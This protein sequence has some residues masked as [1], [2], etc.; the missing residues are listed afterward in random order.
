VT[1]LSNAVAAILIALCSP[2]LA[3]TLTFD[4]MPKGG[5]ALF[6][7]VFGASPDAATLGEMSAPARSEADWNAFLV[8]RGT[9]LGDKDL[10]TLAAYL[11]VNMPVP[12]DTLDAAA[13]AGDVAA[14]LPPDGRELAWNGCQGCHSLFASHLTQDRD[15]QAWQNMFNSPFHRELKMTPQERDEFSRYSAINMPM[16]FEDVPEDLRF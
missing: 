1:R 11:A 3:Q 14:A 5:K 10:R 8:A 9:G 12:G 6:T 4:F 16:K 7:D 2:A 13:K 15:L